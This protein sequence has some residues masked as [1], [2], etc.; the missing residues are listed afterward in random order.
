VILPRDY[1]GYNMGISMSDNERE[2]KNLMKLGAGFAIFGLVCPFFWLSLVSGAPKSETWV[3]GI[4]SGIFI[5]IGLAIMGKGWYDLRR[6]RV[7]IMVKAP[8]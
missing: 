8:E 5:L 7:A 4:H 6:V 2:S 3:Y 1:P